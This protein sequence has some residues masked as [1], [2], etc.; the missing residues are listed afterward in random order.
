MNERHE[1]RVPAGERPRH[2]TKQ[3]IWLLVG[4]TAL[5]VALALFSSVGAR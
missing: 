2:P 3:A 5:I 4:V 1:R